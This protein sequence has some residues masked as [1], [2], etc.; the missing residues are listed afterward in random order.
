MV[1]ATKTYP[2]QDFGWEKAVSTI[3]K[4]VIAN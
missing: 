4:F 1:N 3:S 2:F